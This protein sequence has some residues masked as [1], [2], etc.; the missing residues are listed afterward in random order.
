MLFRP[1]N[2]L[3]RLYNMLFSPHS[4][5]SNLF[6][7]S[8]NIISMLNSFLQANIVYSVTRVSQATILRKGGWIY[9]RVFLGKLLTSDVSPGNLH[10]CN[11]DLIFTLY[12]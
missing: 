3:F 6:V 9:S 11:G 2:M 8:R 4:S 12:D 10:F 1:Y 7:Q 5:H